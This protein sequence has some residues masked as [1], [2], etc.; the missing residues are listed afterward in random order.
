MAKKLKLKVRNS[1][2]L[3]P[4]FVE[5]QNRIN[6]GKKLFFAKLIEDV[7]TESPVILNSN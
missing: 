7:P 1:W 3:T 2:G 6:G 5:V 4:T